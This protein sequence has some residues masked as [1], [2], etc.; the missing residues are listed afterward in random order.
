VEAMKTLDFQPIIKTRALVIQSAPDKLKDPVIMIAEIGPRESGPP[1]HMHP[2]QLET[3]EVLEGEVEFVLGL[4]KI[5]LRAGEKIEIPAQVPHTF[6]NLTTGWLRMKDTHQPALG[7]EEM[8]T[9]LHNLVQRGKV[10]GFKDLKSIIYLSMLWVKF[11]NKQRSVSP[12]YWVMKLMA[13][14]GRAMNYEL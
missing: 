8:M 9:N 12:P 1:L 5:K 10:R 4:K 7:F 11:M 14:L 6:K 3:Y 13:N 2:N